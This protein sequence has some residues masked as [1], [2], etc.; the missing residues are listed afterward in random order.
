[1]PSKHFD[2]RPKDKGAAFS[3]PK[4]IGNKKEKGPSTHLKAIKT[5]RVSGKGDAPTVKFNPQ[6]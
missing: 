4:A 6:W 5:L 3:S 1:L 2:V